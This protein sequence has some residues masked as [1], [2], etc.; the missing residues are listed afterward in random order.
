MVRRSHRSAFG[1]LRPRQL[2]AMVML[3]LLAN[4]VHGLDMAVRRQAQ[5]ANV[6]AFAA[7]GPAYPLHTQP[8]D[9]N[10]SAEVI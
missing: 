2:D 4:P 1:C 7:A 5:H 10:T 6:D 9:D 8:A 3:L